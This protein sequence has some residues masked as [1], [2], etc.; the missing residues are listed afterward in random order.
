MSGPKMVTERE[1]VARERAAFVE[2][3]IYCTAQSDTLN[4][5]PYAQRERLY[6]LPKVSRPRVVRDPHGAAHFWT[7]RDGRIRPSVHW[8]ANDLQT[9]EAITPER[10]ALWADLLA[11]PNEIVEDDGSGSSGA[12]AAGGTSA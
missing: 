12:G 3:V 6:P 1:A 2:G 4:Y 9:I 5:E 8:S 7:V 11:N 10:V